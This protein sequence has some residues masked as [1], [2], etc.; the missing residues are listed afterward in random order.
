MITFRVSKTERTGRSFLLRHSVRAFRRVSSWPRDAIVIWFT[1]SVLLKTCRTPGTWIP[2]YCIASNVWL[3]LTWSWRRKDFLF[4]K[5][6][7]ITRDR[8]KCFLSRRYSIIRSWSRCWIW[9]FWVMPC[10]N[11]ASTGLTK[12]VWN[13]ISSGSD[14]TVFTHCFVNEGIW[15]TSGLKLDIWQTMTKF[16][17][18]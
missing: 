5:C 17:L 7:R 16:W 1:S 3:K 2:I 12:C 15:C 13:R 11:S 4:S 14:W 6:H 10:L 18:G 9:I 8:L